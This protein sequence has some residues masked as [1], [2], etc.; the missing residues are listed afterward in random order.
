MAFVFL[1]ERDVREREI[2]TY[3][4]ESGEFNNFQQRPEFEVD[5]R[6]V[7][8]TG[9]GTLGSVGSIFST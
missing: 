4:D 1:G 5:G 3:I 9:S 6:T 8:I 7:E 2:E